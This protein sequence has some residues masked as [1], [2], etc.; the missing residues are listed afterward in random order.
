MES[1]KL[2]LRDFPFGLWLA[3]LGFLAAAGY[4]FTRGGSSATNTSYLFGLVALLLLFL[5]SVLTITADKT[6]RVLVLRYGLLISRSTKEF[7][8]DEIQT[9]HVNSRTSFDRTDGSRQRS[10]SYRLEIIKKDGQSIPFRSYYSGGFFLKEQQAKKLR[11]FIGLAEGLDE[12]PL[13]ILTNMQKIVQPILEAQQVAL[14]GDNEQ[15]H[16]TDGVKWQLQTIALGGSSVTRWYSQDFSTLDT[17][18]YVTQK[19]QGQKTLYGDG[20]MASI[21]KTLFR[22]VLGMY[23]FSGNDIP[24][25][26]QASVY[27]PLDPVLE[28]SFSAYT[29]EPDSARQLLNPWVQM[30]LAQWAQKYPLKQFQTDANFGQISIMFCPTGTYVATLGVLS[31]E[32]AEEL[33]TLGAELVRAQGST[34]R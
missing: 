11:A 28:S 3:G 27:G 1:E 30:P 4:F 19:V 10:T 2:T 5:P 24:D 12:T 29:D 23:G 9:I 31:L 33:A 13:G 25:V 26:E 16:E 17:F 18:L 22:Q 15:I 32:Q 20:F 6:T 7:S 8:F 34:S 21:G 14:T